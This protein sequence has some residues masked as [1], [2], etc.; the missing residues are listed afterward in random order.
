MKTFT[1]SN[2][3]DDA[4][5]P[6]HGAT[7][8]NSGSAGVADSGQDA[9]ANNEW[10]FSSPGVG[11]SSGTLQLNADLVGRDRV[12]DFTFSGTV[13]FIGEAGGIGNGYSEG[14]SF[15][16]GNPATM[17]ATVEN[18]LATGLS[19]MVS[20]YR[21][22]IAIF[23]NGAQIGATTVTGIEP[24]VPQSFS[25]SVD[26]N[27]HVTASFGTS[28]AAAT[29]PGGAWTTTDQTGWDFVFA[30]R[31]G[32]NTAEGYID[33]MSVNANIVC[34]LAGT[35]VMTPQGP[36]SVELLR[37]GDLVETLDHGAQPLLWAGTRRVPAFGRLAPIEFAPG[38]LGNRN[39]LAL[40]RQ[41]C[42]FFDC[43]E[44]RAHFDPRGVLVRAAHLLGLP[45][46]SRRTGGTAA[47]H[48]I[49]FAR[50]EIVLAEGVPC[51]SLLPAPR[52]LREHPG[53]DAVFPGLKVGV[54]PYPAARRV[55]RRSEVK[56]WRK[57]LAK[58]DTLPFVRSAGVDGSLPQLTVDFRSACATKPDRPES[59][60]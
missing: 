53:L 20:P 54:A 12:T 49:A 24:L 58:Q 33:D 39:A 48:H 8:V 25:I 6:L 37:S 59:R 35:A 16:L 5:N 30:G 19:V 52:Q 36:T 51:E 38:L 11:N 27:G 60:T 15:S 3:F 47:Y 56:H 2:T 9:D 31:S 29:I 32:T 26:T 21:D 18:G 50:H 57:W 14:I 41:H 34:F 45:G 1:Y 46:V 13:D 22:T 44:V 43:P 4:G 28:S 42:L 40:S 23:W 7:A 10:I 17:A 55:L